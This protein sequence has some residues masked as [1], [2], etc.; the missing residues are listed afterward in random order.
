MY[1]VVRMF[2]ENKDK[3]HVYQVGDAYPREGFTPPAGRAE[4]LASGKKGDLNL[5]GE[6]YI[7]LE[8]TKPPAEPEAKK[9]PVATKKA[10][11]EAAAAPKEKK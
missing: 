4:A 3:G 7:A 11:E 6:V 8:E 10:E 9:E 1:K 5:V 2:R